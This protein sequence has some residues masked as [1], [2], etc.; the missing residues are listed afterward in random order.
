MLKISKYDV[1]LPV[2]PFLS[3]DCHFIY[4]NLFLG[5]THLN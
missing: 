1:D 2:S 3:T 4:V 5:T